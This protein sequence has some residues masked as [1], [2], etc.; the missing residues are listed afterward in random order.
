MVGLMATSSKRFYAIPRSTEPRGP[1]PADPYFRRKH[2]N[3]VLA[4]S[5]WGLWVFVCTRF[6]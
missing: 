1:A 6:V 3:I 5:L 2:S 4:Q